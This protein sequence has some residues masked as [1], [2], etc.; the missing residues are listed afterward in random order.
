VKTHH[1]RA[2]VQPA[3]QPASQPGRALLHPAGV[4]SSPRSQQQAQRM[5]AAFGLGVAGAAA[6]EDKVPVQRY[7]TPSVMRFADLSIGRAQNAGIVD[8]ARELGT[9]LKFTQHFHCN[10]W[11]EAT[12]TFDSFTGTFFGVHLPPAAPGATTYHYTITDAG[13]AWVGGA[14]APPNG[15]MAMAAATQAKLAALTAPA[16]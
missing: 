7:V 14:G 11:A 16:V 13:G 9:G 10:G 2:D 4:A 12:R 1:A 5:T 8:E 3:R 15:A 6:A